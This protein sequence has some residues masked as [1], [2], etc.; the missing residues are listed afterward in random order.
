MVHV[1]SEWFGDGFHKVNQQ[2]NSQYGM[3]K[4][5]TQDDEGNF[6]PGLGGDTTLIGYYGDP[7]TVHLTVGYRF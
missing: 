4:L 3:Q 1:L 2:Q 7:R 6:G 5:P